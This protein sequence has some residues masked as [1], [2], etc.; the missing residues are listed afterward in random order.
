MTLNSG[1]YVKL[2]GELGVYYESPK[3]QGIFIALTGGIPC[4]VKPSDLSK[5][6][7]DEER[8][9]LQV[10]NNAIFES[11]QVPMKEHM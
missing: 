3:G 5:D 4:K 9:I 2:E 1:D 11:L 7:T 8:L 10:L 6:F